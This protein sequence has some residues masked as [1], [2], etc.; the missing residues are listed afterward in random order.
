MS[1]KIEVM[2]TTEPGWHSNALRFPTEE[3]ASEWA[4]DLFMRWMLVK[5]TRVRVV[6]EPAL[7]RMLGGKVT[8]I[9]TGDET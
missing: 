4:A 8:F 5:Q 3:E 7:N 1:W 9:N 6:P 2:L